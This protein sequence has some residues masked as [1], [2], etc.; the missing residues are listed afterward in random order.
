VC[1]IALVNPGDVVVADVDGVVVVPAS[2]AG[3]VAE[4]GREHEALEEGKRQRF[5]AGELGLDVYSMRQLL[6]AAGLRYID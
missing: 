3:E 4:A 1:A 5:A 6:E 2:R